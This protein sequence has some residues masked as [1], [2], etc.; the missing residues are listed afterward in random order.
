MEKLEKLNKSM[1]RF[2]SLSREMRL[3]MLLSYA[4]RFPELPEELREARDQGLNRVE[5]CQTPLFLWIGLD[6]GKVTIHA[7]APPEAP[8]VR[9]F[10]AFLMEHL[11]G[12]T[13]QEILAMPKDVLEQMGLGE[14]LGVMRTNGLSH[15]LIRIRRDVERLQD[16]A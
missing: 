13:P 4:R 5:E 8:T 14:V 15:V 7:D 16:P 11:Q 3:Q 9:G 2:R 12:A 1:V 10:M 6:E